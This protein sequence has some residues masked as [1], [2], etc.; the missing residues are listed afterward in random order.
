MQ[1]K[2]VPAC[3]G[4]GGNG[5]YLVCALKVFYEYIW[6]DVWVCTFVFCGSVRWCECI[7]WP[8]I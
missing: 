1:G 3:Q 6:E 5:V 8:A 2:I 4:T 7:H